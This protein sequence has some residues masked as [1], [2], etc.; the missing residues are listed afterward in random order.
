[1]KALILGGAR[2]GK[3]KLAEQAALS[4]GLKCIYIAT[5]QAGDAEMIRRIEKHRERRG[6]EWQLMEEPVALAS[7]LERA[8]AEDTCILVDCLTL[9]LSNCLFSEDKA[10]WSRQREALLEILPQLPGHIILVSNETGL[11]VVPMGEVTRQFVD[12]SGL[13]HQALAEI[14]D[15]VTLT[16]AGLPHILKD[17][18]NR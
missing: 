13:L 17:N 5:A 6:A 11:G 2:S 15:R 3:S 12:E 14:C 16:V 8:A 4:S 7:A 9:W 18:Q 10:E 1:M